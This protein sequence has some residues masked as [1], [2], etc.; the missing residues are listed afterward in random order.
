MTEQKVHT[1][2]FSRMMRFLFTFIT[3]MIPSAKDLFLLTGAEEKINEW[4]N[5]PTWSKWSIR[6]PAC[7][8]PSS[9][10]PWNIRG[11]LPSWCTILIV[12]KNQNH[13]MYCEFHHMN[14]NSNVQ[15][16]FPTVFFFFV[17]W[18]YDPLKPIYPFICQLKQVDSATYMPTQ[19][20]HK[21]IWLLVTEVES[22]M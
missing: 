7:V 8:S 13:I 3:T 18:M 21:Q 1:C 14:I 5:I 20:Y 11:V 22:F 2:A 17:C 6:E 4:D 16:N 19:P 10:Q 9:S 12:K 15:I